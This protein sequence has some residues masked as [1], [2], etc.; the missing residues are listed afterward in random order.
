M[1]IPQPLE[2]RVEITRQ[3]AHRLEPVRLHMSA[4][5]NGLHFFFPAFAFG[6]GSTL[7]A[8]ASV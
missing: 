7:S 3:P 8:S 5:V 4:V 1:V 6:A 2:D